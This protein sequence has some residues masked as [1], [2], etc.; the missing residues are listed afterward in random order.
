MALRLLRL[1]A[2]KD[3]T[4]ANTNEIYEAMK[5]GTF[6]SAVAIGKRTVGWVEAEIDCWIEQRIAQRQSHPVKRRGGPGR[7]HK[8][9]MMRDR[10]D[11]ALEL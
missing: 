6:P 1:P 9:P 2:V 3:K 7:G 8:G 4:G 5:A 11:S 10:K